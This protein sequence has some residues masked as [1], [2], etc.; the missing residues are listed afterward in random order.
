LNVVSTMREPGEDG[1]AGIA[2]IELAPFPNIEAW[3]SR[4]GS[5]A[6]NRRVAALS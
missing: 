4:C 6:A 1:I 5:R 3:P 2:Q